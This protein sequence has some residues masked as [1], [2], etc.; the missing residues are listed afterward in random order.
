MTLKSGNYIGTQFHSAFKGKL[1][2]VL[3]DYRIISTL[4]QNRSQEVVQILSSK[5][6]SISKMGKTVRLAQLFLIIPL[7]Y[8]KFLWACILAADTKQ[9][10]NIWKQHFITNCVYTWTCFCCELFTMIMFFPECF[11]N[12]SAELTLSFGGNMLAKR[13][14]TQKFV[15]IKTHFWFKNFFKWLSNWLLFRLIF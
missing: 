2:S 4:A 14:A 12:V 1:F 15:Y 10:E 11:R 5:L 8:G 6:N 13:K 9:V 7:C 3:L